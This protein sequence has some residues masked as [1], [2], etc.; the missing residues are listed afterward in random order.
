MVVTLQ[1]RSDSKSLIGSHHRHCR[2]SHGYAFELLFCLLESST[3]ISFSLLASSFSFF[4]P[5]HVCGRQDLLSGHSTPHSTPSR[6]TCS[7]CVQVL[8]ISIIVNI[9][10]EQSSFF[11]TNTQYPYHYILGVKLE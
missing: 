3:T 7:N 4:F 9:Y 8:M 11:N 10:L 5:Q 2:C 6:L 1:F